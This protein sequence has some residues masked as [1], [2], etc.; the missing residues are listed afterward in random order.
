MNKLTIQQRLNLIEKQ[1]LPDEEE[2]LALVR[3][4]NLIRQ[5]IN[6][7]KEELKQVEKLS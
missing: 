1:L 3:R 6:E 7:I 4:I 5:V 2:M